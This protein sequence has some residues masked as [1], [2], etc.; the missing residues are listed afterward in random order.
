MEISKLKSI[1]GACACL[2][3][4][5]G[6]SV[7]T[8][9]V[10]QTRANSPQKEYIKKYY[11]EA[12][13]QMERHGIPASITLAQGILETGSGKSSLARKHNNHFGIKCAGSWTGKRTYARDDKY[14]DCFRSY[15]NWRDSFEDHSLF[16][17]KRRY[18]KLFKL[19]PSDYRGWAKGLQKA[20]YASSR[21]YACGLIDLIE[22]YELYQFDRGAYPSWFLS[23]KSGRTRSITR[24][25][26]LR[27]IFVSSGLHY[28]VA[29]K[30][31]TFALIAKELDL[32]SVRLARYNELE[33]SS[34]L[35]EGAIIYLE[36]KHS[37]ANPPYKWHTVEVGES[38]YT[39]AQRY[40]MLIKSLYLLNDKS[41]DYI[42]EV[43]DKLRLR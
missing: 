21:T 1:L 27:Q 2:L 17:K 29:K 12:L 14:N 8:P 5:V 36:P 23:P 4:L 28:I 22:R 43:G 9:K 35:K 6:C 42:P 38:M 33:L 25:E 15:R 41:P 31:D 30:G 24:S 16:L 34:P 20:H 7:R 39:I 13:R 19:S 32:S 40:G 3:V 18:R 37:T 11:A 26:T 10:Q